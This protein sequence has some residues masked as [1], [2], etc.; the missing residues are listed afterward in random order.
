MINGITWQFKKRNFDL[1]IYFHL[2]VRKTAIKLVSDSPLII[3]GC[4]KTFF[5]PK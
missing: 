1:D 3:G 5:V 2:Q 4:Y